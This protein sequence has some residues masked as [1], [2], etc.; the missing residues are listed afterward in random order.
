MQ[1]FDKDPA[2]VKDYG[3]NWAG[4]VGDDTITDVEVTVEGAT[5]DPGSVTVG[6]PVIDGTI[7]KAVVSG[8]TPRR[9]YVLRFHITTA[10]ALEDELSILLVVGDQ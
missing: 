6:E 4:V 3:I 5:D 9:N 8:G 10:G 1:R 2:A 7:T